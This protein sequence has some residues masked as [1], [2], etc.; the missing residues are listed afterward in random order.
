MYISLPT[1]QPPQEEGV[2]GPGRGI[3]TAFSNKVSA[4]ITITKWILKGRPEHHFLK[5]PQTW[6]LP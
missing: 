1:H 3:T 6:T 4:F 5:C 2:M